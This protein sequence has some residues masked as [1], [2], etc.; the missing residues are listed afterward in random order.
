M[1]KVEKVII[2]KAEK[3]TLIVEGSSAALAYIGGVLVAKEKNTK[4]SVEIRDKKDVDLF[5]AGEGKTSN[6]GARAGGP[7]SSVKKES[8]VKRTDNGINKS[9]KVRNVIDGVSKQGAI[10][11]LQVAK[12]TGLKPS[13]ICEPLIRMSKSGKI[14]RTD[15]KPYKYFNINF[16]ESQNRQAAGVD[17]VISCGIRNGKKIAKEDCVP[18]PAAREC[19]ACPWGR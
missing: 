4:L 17:G 5:L 14:G 19:K 3:E 16:K 7:S 11:N 15:E 12:E 6:V 1:E 13:E 10:T 2:I 18:N 8:L 9:E